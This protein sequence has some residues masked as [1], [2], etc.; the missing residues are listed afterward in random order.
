[1]SPTNSFFNLF[2]VGCDATTKV[3]SSTTNSICKVASAVDH[4][5]GYLANQAERAELTS[6]QELEN[7]KTR[8]EESKHS[9]KMEIINELEEKS[10]AID[11]KLLATFKKRAAFLG[12]EYDPANFAK[13]KAALLEKYKN[14]FKD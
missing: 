6:A 10:L 14:I 8:I 5:A 4:G 2:G 7:T 1:M 13:D 9:L 12:Q 3:I 11:E